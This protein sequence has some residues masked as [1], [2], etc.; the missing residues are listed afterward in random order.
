MLNLI[1][2]IK[3]R[4]VKLEEI[5]RN[6]QQT[7]QLFSYNTPLAY[8]DLSNG[9]TEDKMKRIA[10]QIDKYNINMLSTPH[11]SNVVRNAIVA[12]L[13]EIGLEYWLAVRKYREDYDKETQIK[14][15]TSALKN[16]S[17]NTLNF[18]VVVNRY[19]EAIDSYNN[20]NSNKLNQLCKT[21]N[22][23]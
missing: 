3:D 18:G 19:K 1:Q 14:R 6:Q 9:T 21:K 13:G 5:V 16:R 8:V 22:K 15:Y 4:I 10:E 2:E 7:Q 12:V 23:A 11:N 20:T 17:K